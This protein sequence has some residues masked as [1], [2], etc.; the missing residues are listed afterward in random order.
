MEVERDGR[1]MEKDVPRRDGERLE[2]VDRAA[3]ITDGVDRDGERC[4]D[5]DIRFGDGW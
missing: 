2:D 1:E 3:I 5:I 4:T